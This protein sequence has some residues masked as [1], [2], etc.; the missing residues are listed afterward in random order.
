[1]QQGNKAQCSAK[2]QAQI[3]KLK[4]RFRESTRQQIMEETGTKRV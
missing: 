4:K 3:K 1:M 2:T